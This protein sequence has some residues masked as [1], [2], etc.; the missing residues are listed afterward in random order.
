MNHFEM[1]RRTERVVV[2]IHWELM[3]GIFH[4]HVDLAYLWKHAE[5]VSLAGDTVLS[6]PIEEL[7]LFLC[8]H[9]AKHSWSRLSWICDVALLIRARPELE[10]ELILRQA[11][12]VGSERVFLLALHMA[13]RFLGV[14]LPEGVLRAIQRDPRAQSLASEVYAQRLEQIKGA[15]STE[16]DLRFYLD[17]KERSIDKFRCC[18][19]HEQIPTGVSREALPLRVRMSLGVLSALQPNSEDSRL[20]NLP[21]PLHFLYYFVRPLR[22]IAK[23]ALSPAKVYRKIFGDS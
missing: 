11:R 14:N 13:N 18:R 10:L 3:P 4:H 22:L 20:L 15:S 5:P 1:I 16:E 23:Y 9:G 6:F 12:K 7:M 2:E 21:R 19:K 8:A 17:A